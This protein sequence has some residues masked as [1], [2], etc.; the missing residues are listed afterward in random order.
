ML[1][2][3]SLEG[4]RRKRWCAGVVLFAV[5][6]LTL[7]VATRYCFSEVASNHCTTTVHKQSSRQPS[8]QRLMKNAADWMPPVVGT[9]V[10]HAPASYPH[11]A[12]A[13]PAIPSL[14]IEHKLYT[15]PPPSSEFLS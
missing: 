3:T 2:L 5:C 1:R 15:R 6:S 11:V 9:A 13:A 4:S 14:F 8:R 10:F 12:L 7:S